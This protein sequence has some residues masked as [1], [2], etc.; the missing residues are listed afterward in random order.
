MF[1]KVYTLSAWFKHQSLVAW[2]AKQVKR[3]GQSIRVWRVGEH[4]QG[5]CREGGWMGGCRVDEEHA[6]SMKNMVGEQDMRGA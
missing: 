3:V 6:G 2:K 4:V 1:L 5:R